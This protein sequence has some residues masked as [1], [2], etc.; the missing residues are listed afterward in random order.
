MAFANLRSVRL[1]YNLAGAEDAPV[2]VFSHSLGADLSMWDAQVLE[3]SRRYRVLRYD[4]RGHGE[5]SL[6]AGP[7][8][9]AAMAGDVLD[10]LDYLTIPVV[11]FCG[12]SL[13]GLTGL[14]LAAQAP[15]RIRKVVACS[16]A[17]KI[18]TQESW[19]SR[20]ELVRREGM[21][22]VVP[23]I[24]ERWFTPAFHVKAP[25]T[26]RT[27]ERVLLGIDVDGYAAGCAAVRDTDLREGLSAVVPTLLANG[28]S[29]PVTPP[30]DGR[31]LA[32]LIPRARFLEFAGA[33]M[34]TMESAAEFT[35]AVLG[36]L[37]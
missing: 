16:A 7:H 4:T 32:G 34:F 19:D 20:I 28:A 10:L 26:I 13:G 3:F 23:G 21:K 33:H 18:G 24:L 17:A 9:V 36:F 29:D 22:A 8:T 6:P 5:S 11:S 1:H 14:S 35:S 15:K 25:E 27:T 12:L 37:D 31:A 30:S 2:V